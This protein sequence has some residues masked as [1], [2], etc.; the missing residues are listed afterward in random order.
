MPQIINN[1]LIQQLKIQLLSLENATVRAVGKVFGSKHPTVEAM[2]S[3]IIACKVQIDAEIEQISASIKNEY[4][5]AQAQENE[6][7]LALEHRKR[8]PGVQSKIHSVIAS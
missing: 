4:E 7:F 3:Q 5:I 6:L 1:P 2:D 8:K